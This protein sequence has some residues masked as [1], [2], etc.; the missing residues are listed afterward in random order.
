MLEI[1]GQAI[2]E[3]HFLDFFSVPNLVTVALHKRSDIWI[4]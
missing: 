4:F 3:L 1:Y 2:T